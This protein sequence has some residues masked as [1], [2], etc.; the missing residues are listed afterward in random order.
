MSENLI[1]LGGGGHCKSCIDVIESTSLFKIAGILDPKEPKGL[2]ILGY[3][4]LGDDRNNFVWHTLY[5]V[6]R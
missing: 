4:I 2:K 6:I 3:E 5:E 1:L